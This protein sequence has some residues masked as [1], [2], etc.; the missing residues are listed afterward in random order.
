M[1]ASG[2]PRKQ[3]LFRYTAPNHVRQK[4]V[5]A[6]VAKELAKKLGIKKRS[7]G[8]RRGDTVKVMSGNSRGKNGKVSDVDLR[9]AVVF[10]EGIARKTA[11]GREI[12]IPI[13]ASNVYITDLNLTN[14]WRSAKIQAERAEK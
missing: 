3:R 14:K 7:V 13:S 1:I 8:V 12:Q 10:I 4:F 2:K 6:H 9:R 11:K 5:H